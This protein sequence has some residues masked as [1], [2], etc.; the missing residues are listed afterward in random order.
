MAAAAVNSQHAEALK[1]RATEVCTES[2]QFNENLNQYGFAL[3]DVNTTGFSNGL[4]SLARSFLRQNNE[5]AFQKVCVY[6]WGKGGGGAAA[7]CLLAH[8]C[9]ILSS[10][11]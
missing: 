2:A 6:N 3:C 7:C 10:D 1:A 5:A 11:I 4:P 8:R 9:T